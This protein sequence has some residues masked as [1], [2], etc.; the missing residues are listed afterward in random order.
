M[1]HFKLCYKLAVVALATLATFATSSLVLKVLGVGVLDTFYVIFIYPLTNLINF[2]EVINRM[3]P[4]CIVALGIC[5]AYRSGIINIGGEGQMTVGLL[6]TIVVILFTDLPR[7]VILPLALL[8]G[9]LGGALWGFIPGALKAKFGVSELLSTVMLNYIAA[10]IYAYCLRVPL[11]DPTVIGGAGDPQ[12]M[13]LAKTAWLSKLNFWIPRTAMHTG[14]FIALGLA[15]LVYCFMWRTSFGYK[16]RAAGSSERA[17]RYGG[18]HVS[19]YLVLAMLISGGC[20]GL[21][22]AIEVMGVHH[23]GVMSITGGYGFSGI[24]VALFGG[25]HPAGIIP[26][27]FLFGLLQ[28]GA[29]ALQIMGIPVP[30]NM[31]DVLQGIVILV[32][33]ATKMILQ[34]PYLMDRAQRR[35]E[36]L[37]GRKAGV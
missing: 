2:S 27:A 34:N 8:C 25:L 20:A 19:K 13:R 33:V 1:K 12:T 21:A 32:I 3:T 30:S 26:A 35:V 5:V 16:M 6:L 9:I 4:L 22:G 36:S 18:I 15:V 28:Y 7:P 10:Q 17:A 23:R 11:L 37:L 31:V 24:V 29:S 14:I